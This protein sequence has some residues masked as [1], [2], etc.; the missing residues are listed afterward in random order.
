MTFS[1]KLIFWL[2][3]SVWARGSVGH[4]AIVLTNM[5]PAAW[6]P[7]VM[8]WI[9]TLTFLRGGLLTYATGYAGSGRGPLAGPPSLT[10]AH[11][12]MVEAKAAT[13]P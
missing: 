10:E 11:Q 2:A 3:F 1:P 5:I 13:K 8:A 7:T 9:G 12:V 4:G 6:I